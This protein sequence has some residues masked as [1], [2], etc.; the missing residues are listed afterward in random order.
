MRLYSLISQQNTGRLPLSSTSSTSQK[1]PGGQ[2]Y[3]NEDD[4]CQHPN[5]YAGQA[6]AADTTSM[7]NRKLHFKA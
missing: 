1:L 4:I 2:T 7:F 5:K 6:E 3:P